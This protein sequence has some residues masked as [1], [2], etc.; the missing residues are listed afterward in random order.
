MTDSDMKERAQ[1]IAMCIDGRPVYELTLSM[2]REAY[3]SG[4]ADALA[5]IP[6]SE[7]VDNGTGLIVSKPD[8][9]RALWPYQDNCD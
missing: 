8:P 5:P 7:C 2:L 4:K 1:R 6:M 3:A 9:L